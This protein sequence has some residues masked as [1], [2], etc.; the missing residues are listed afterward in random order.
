MPEGQDP[1]D[2]LAAGGGASA[3]A[4][5]DALDAAEELPVFHAR[6]L[7]D[8]ADLDSPAGRDRALDEVVEVI[9]AM[10]DSITRAELQREV[11]DRLGAEPELVSRRIAAAGRAPRRQAPAA[12]AQSPPPGADGQAAAAEPERPRPLS[13]R[14]R[15][16]LALL[17]MCVKLPAEGAEMIERL[18]ERALLVADRGRRAALAARSPRGAD[19]A[20]CRARTRRCGAT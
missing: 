18:D 10:P 20:T 9:A 6:T 5:R 11:A 4:F 15:R 8:D 12:A 14:E 17:A 2:L 7:L 1:A 13:A 19:A 16:E 3:A